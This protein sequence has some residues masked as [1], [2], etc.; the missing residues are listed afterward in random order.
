MIA[1]HG[2]GYALRPHGP[3]RPERSGPSDLGMPMARLASGGTITGWNLAAARLFGWSAAQALGRH[4]SILAPA[5]DGALERD[6]QAL[7][8]G[9]SLTGVLRQVQTRSGRRLTVVLFAAPEPVPNGTTPGARLALIDVSAVARRSLRTQVLA[10]ALEQA[11]NPIVIADRAGRVQYANRA[12]LERA[13]T[14]EGRPGG[15][16]FGGA[17]D[18]TGRRQFDDVARALEADG[19][20]DGDVQSVRHG[21]DACWEH[22][23]IYALKAPDGEP[24]YYVRTSVDVTDRRLAEV[25]LRQLAYRDPLTGLFNRAALTAYLERIARRPDRTGSRLAALFMDCDGFKAVNDTY[26]HLAG[27]VTLRGLAGTLNGCLRQGDFVARVSGDEFVAIVEV[28]DR[29]DAIVIAN[30]IRRAV[31]AGPVAHIGSNPIRLGVSIGVAI[32]PDDV[33]DPFHLIHTADR[34]MYEA[35]ARG[36][37]RAVAYAARAK[38][39]ALGGAPRPVVDR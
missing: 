20:W 37:G 31:A 12:H 38:G 35:K 29:R 6:V 7:Q 34:A 25:Q 8:R 13:G 2:P 15:S 21:S 32:Y 26:G 27:D 39:V 3:I 9:R 4:L 16:I 28:G 19:V 5:G 24:A 14:A 33:Q 23:T 17:N 10:E 30:K 18:Q 36:K 11:P 1:R 22:T